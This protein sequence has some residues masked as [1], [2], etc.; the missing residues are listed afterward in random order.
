MRYRR[1]A[2][3]LLDF[4]GHIQIHTQQI[5]WTVQALREK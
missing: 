3:M 5:Q 2:R 1:I 4:A